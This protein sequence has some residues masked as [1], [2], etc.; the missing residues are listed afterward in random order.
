MPKLVVNPTAIRDMVKMDSVIRETL[1]L[2]AVAGHGMMR[3]VTAPGGVTTP[4]GLYLPQG[5]NISASVIYPHYVSCENGDE[6][7]PLRFYDM[8]VSSAAVVAG[9]EGQDQE[10]H[11]TP[12]K[13]TMAVQISDQFLSFGLGKHACP[14]RFFAV[15]SMKLMLGY[16]VTRY[17]IEPCVKPPKMIEIGEGAIPSSKT[18]LRLRRRRTGE[19]KFAEDPLN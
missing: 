12:K 18:L 8:A 9:R 6:W 10:S 13:Q 11:A 3:R 14:G 15:Q 19:Q 7:H 16:L 17:D 1:R 5:S 2:S 4:D